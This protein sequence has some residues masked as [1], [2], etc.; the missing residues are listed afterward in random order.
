M[1]MVRAYIQGMQMPPPNTAR[2]ANCLLNRASLSGSENEWI[3]FE[4]FMIMALPGVVG[5]QVGITIAIV[6]AIDRAALVA[7]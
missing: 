5:A 4:L 2:F 3:S 6:K 1:H 7:V